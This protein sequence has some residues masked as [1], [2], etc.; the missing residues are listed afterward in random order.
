MNA[1]GYCSACIQLYML[2]SL[3]ATKV[4]GNARDFYLYENSDGQQRGNGI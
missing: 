2:T 4:N 1:K 3:F